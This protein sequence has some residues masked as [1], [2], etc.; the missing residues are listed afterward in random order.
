MISKRHD[1]I[2]PEC[3]VRGGMEYLDDILTD[4]DS[5]CVLNLLEMQK[6]DLKS[7]HM[8]NYFVFNMQQ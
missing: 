6:Q 3:T 4:I 8:K 7:S 5:R 2:V 1:R